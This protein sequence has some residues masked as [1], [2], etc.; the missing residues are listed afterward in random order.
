MQGWFAS[1]V[2]RGFNFKSNSSYL[3]MATKCCD[4]ILV[5]TR[6]LGE[7]S[8]TASGWNMYHHYYYVAPLIVKRHRPCLVNFWK[9]LCIFHRATLQQ[10]SQNMW[11][12]CLCHL[13]GLSTLENASPQL[14]NHLWM[15]NSIS[16]NFGTARVLGNLY[17]DI[18]N[19]TLQ[20]KYKFHF[21]SLRQSRV[22]P[23]L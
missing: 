23:Y 4:V 14:S 7:Q 10:A 5:C 18:S 2:S 8:S 9:N 17:Q 13:V 19:N 12:T 22:Y 11:Y 21:Y 15:P 1:E 6:Q 20:S 3:R 16:K